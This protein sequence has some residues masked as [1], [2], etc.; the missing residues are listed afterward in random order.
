M[1]DDAFRRWI[2]LGA[3]AALVLAA[4][5]IVVWQLRYGIAPGF[6][7]P[8]EF[9]RAHPVAWMAVLLLVADVVIHR[10]WTSPEDRDVEIH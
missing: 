7:W 6:E 9:G 5:Y 3:P 1:R 4:A 8:T 2:A 10:A